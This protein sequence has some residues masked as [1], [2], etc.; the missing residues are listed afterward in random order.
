MALNAI[1]FYDV[2]LR[3]LFYSYTLWFE[4]A[5]GFDR[6]LAT[7][8]N[9]N[10]NGGTPMESDSN[11][12]A[13]ENSASSSFRGEAVKPLG[14]D[15]PK[16]GEST[17]HELRVISI[18]NIH[19][20][21]FAEPEVW[22][23]LEQNGVAA[24]CIYIPECFYLVPIG[25]IDTRYL[26][27]QR[28]QGFIPSPW[29]KSYVDIL[30]YVFLCKMLQRPNRN[31]SRPPSTNESQK[32]L[33]FKQSKVDSYYSSAKAPV[34]I[35]PNRK[36][37][38][39]P[40]KLNSSINR[41]GRRGK[42]IEDSAPYDGSSSYRMGQPQ[43]FKFPE[44]AK[45]GAGG[46]A[47]ST[48][49]FSQ[50]GSSSV[51]FATPKHF[52]NV[53]ES[54]KRGEKK[55]QE[56]NDFGAQSG[57]ELVPY[58]GVCPSHCDPSLLGETSYVEAVSLFAA[59]TLLSLR[60]AWNTVRE[61]TF[62]S[63]ARNFRCQVVE[64]QS[65][66]ELLDS[67][68]LESFVYESIRLSVFIC[69]ILVFGGMYLRMLIWSFAF[70]MTGYTGLVTMLSE[71]HI[72]KVSK[73]H[74][75]KLVQTASLSESSAD[76]SDMQMSVMSPV[77]VGEAAVEAAIVKYGKPT[78]K[79]LVLGAPE[80]GDIDLLYVIGK[81]VRV[82]IE[83]KSSGCSASKAMKQALKYGQVVSILCPT[84]VV[85]CFTVA[86]SRLKMVGHFGVTKPNLFK[87]IPKALRDEISSVHL[88]K[89]L[90]K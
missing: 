82:V 58:Q 81:K 42:P 69:P 88:E 77:E 54:V 41:Q 90:V 67:I 1:N 75:I 50:P 5:T 53:G 23:D 48:M 62:L 35:L 11:M 31:L 26:D 24:L 13:L 34:S 52:A 17:P 36:D 12:S 4:L 6:R 14:V 20:A 59:T 2:G 21:V 43:V 85:Y 16:L 51:S 19:A 79:N 70:M 55:E 3:I 86:D 32:K 56:W 66:I 71:R 33:N 47:S 65:G 49:S 84:T 18:C 64:P 37:T 22:R 87:R 10:D 40:R 73:Q 39:I 8:Q 63:K 78:H 30:L 45:P 44:P 74:S 46:N 57:W 60:T 76:I 28:A 25:E 61:S 15:A 83:V 7:I 89:Y 72:S 80:M 29:C 38:V 9:N 27:V 68:N